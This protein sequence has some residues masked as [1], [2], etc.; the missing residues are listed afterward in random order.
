[1]SISKTINILGVTGSIGQAVCDVIAANPG[2]FDVDVITAHTDEHGLLEAAKRLGAKQSILTSREVLVLE[3]PVDIT[4]CAIVG[5]AGLPSMMQA[6]ETSKIVAIANKEPLVAAGPLVLENA[7]R[8]GTTLLPIDS[9]HN[10]VFQVFDEKNRQGIEKIVLTASGG[11]FRAW[12]KEKMANATVEEALKHPTWSMGDK[13]SIDSATM[14]N[15]ALEI[16]EA[17]YLFGVKPS[18]IEVVVHPQSVVH[19]LVQYSDGSILTQMGASDMRTPIAYVLGYPERIQSGGEVLD[20]QSLSQLTFEAPD[21]EKFPFLSMA[22]ECLERG[23][24][25]C[26]VLNAA[27]EVAVDAFLTKRIGFGDIFKIVQD[28]LD[29][30]GARD[31]HCLDDVMKLDHEVRAKVRQSIDINT[32]KAAVS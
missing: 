32:R 26:I 10:A 13:I 18:Q 17:H 19:S 25:A 29:Q 9:E 23:P 1:M 11:P 7:K 3:R 8:H 12:T 15:K 4:V 14:A 28:C 20:V 30:T 31:I 5:M 24:Y 16:I 6:I 21:R 2:M 22:Y 27:N